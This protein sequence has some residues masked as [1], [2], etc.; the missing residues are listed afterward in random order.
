MASVIYA[1]SGEGRG[2]ATRARVVVEALRRRHRLTLFASECAYDLLAPRYRGTDVRVVRIPGLHFAYGA[3]GR[4]NLVRTLVEAALFRMELGDHVRRVMPEL[5]RARPDLIIADFEPIAPRAAQLRGVP[6]VSFDHQHYLVVSDLSALPF[7]LRAQARAAAPF[8]QA[9]Y[10]WQR[11]TIVSSFYNAPIKRAYQNT[12]WVGTL[13]RPELMGIKPERGG[14][15][16]G[17]I[18]RQASPGTLAALASCGREVRLYGLGERPSQGSLRFLA[19][20]E[21]RFLDDLASCQAVISTAGNQLVGEALYL[22]K[23]MLVM[24]EALNFEQAVNAYFLERTGA[25][26][27][28]RGSLTSRLLGAFLEAVPA[29]QPRLR[30]EALCGNDDAVAAIERHLGARPAVVRAADA[31]DAALADEEAAA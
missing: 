2:H 23:P 14:H 6:F 19:I 28:E 30:P 25:G 31:A 20:D 27:A 24:P 7:S 21:R 8:V 17:Y 22:R 4:V 5:D 18:R 1:M 3:P 15:L 11:A 16:V 9:L 10:D 13:I 12:T 26:W 29:L